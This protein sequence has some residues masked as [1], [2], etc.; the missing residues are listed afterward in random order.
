MIVLLAALQLPLIEKP[1]PGPSPYFVLLLTGDGGWRAIDE[2]LTA[3]M[4]RN[5]I[6]VAGLLSD[7]YFRDA[8]TPDEVARDVGAAMTHYAALW[9]K[10]KVILIGFSRGADAL[11]VALARMP[12][13]MRE[14]VA[15]A[16]LLG[17]STVAELHVVPFWRESDVP[18]IALAPLMRTISDVPVVCVHGEDE[19]NSLCDVLPLGAVKD[20]KVDGGHHFAGR[21]AE[22]ARTILAMVVRGGAPGFST[23]GPAG[24]KGT[25]SPD[26]VGRPRP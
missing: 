17:P 20:V 2:G 7:R 25:A 1:A 9:K 24:R 10:R 22:I 13:A 21:Y 3:E 23:P 14:R 5:G 15:L 16:A 19:E 6:P 8:R 18:S 12:A 11:P 26:A 4:Q